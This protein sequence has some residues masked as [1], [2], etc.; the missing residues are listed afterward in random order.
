VMMPKMSGVELGKRVA[1]ERPETKIILMSGHHNED[2]IDPKYPFLK[3]PFSVSK[4][5]DTIRGL[6]PPAQQTRE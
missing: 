3:K 6:V 5:S 2:N 1:A 4:L